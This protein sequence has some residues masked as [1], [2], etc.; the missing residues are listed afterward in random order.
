[1]TYTTLYAQIQSYINRTNDSQLNAQ[2]DNFI[3]QAQQRICRESKS[4][5]LEVYVSSSFT[6][7]TSV[8]PKP[9]NWRRTLSINYGT[10][11]TPIS[12]SN[13]RNQLILRSYEF[14]RSYWPNDSQTAAPI[15]YADYGYNNILISP[16]P[17]QDYPWEFCYLSLPEP[18]NSTS[19]TNW[20]TNYA[21]DVLL[22][23]SLLEAMPFLKNDDR[24]QVWSSLYEKGLE[25]LNGQDDMRKVDRASNRDSD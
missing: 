11:G 21:P 3:Y 13:S 25:S 23:A 10:G 17:D 4:V 12:N 1:M 6:T 2:I 9:S 20:L 14:C 18:L 16:T 22:Y 19:Q 24:I 5:G 15:Y 8:Y 7:G